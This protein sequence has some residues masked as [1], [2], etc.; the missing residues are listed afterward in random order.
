MAFIPPE[1]RK[2]VKKVLEQYGIGKDEDVFIHSLH[3]TNIPTDEHWTRVLH[4]RAE[5]EAK[6]MDCNY[7]C[8]ICGKHHD[9]PETLTE[10]LQEHFDC[11]SAGI[12]IDRTDEHIE[13]LLSNIHP[14]HRERSEKILRGEHP[15]PYRNYQKK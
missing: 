11:F 9:V 6:D 5:Y 1:A 3:T 15:H 4:K 8:F 2:K 7:Y 14:R 12:P 10:C 13:K